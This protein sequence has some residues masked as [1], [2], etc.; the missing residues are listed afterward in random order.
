MIAAV[1]TPEALKARWAKLTTVVAVLSTA[2]L[3]A[4]LLVAGKPPVR[5][6]VLWLGFFPAMWMALRIV[7]AIAWDTSFKATARFKLPASPAQV[8][9]AEIASLVALL[10]VHA[11]ASWALALEGFALAILLAWIFYAAAALVISVAVYLPALLLAKVL[12]Q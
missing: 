9:L 4:A 12:V 1:P 3:S 2:A 8:F 7:G 6:W 5:L 10:A 11:I